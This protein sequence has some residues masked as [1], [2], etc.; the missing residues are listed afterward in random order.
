MSA[1]GASDVPSRTVVAHVHSQA[2]ILCPAFA[3]LIEAY[4][5]VLMELPFTTDVELPLEFFTLPVSSASSPSSL[6]TSPAHFTT[7][8]STKKPT[9]TLKAPLPLVP[10]SDLE[11]SAKFALVV[12]N[13]PFDASPLLRSL[14]A[15][16][17][18]LSVYA[19]G[20]AHRLFK[21]T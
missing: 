21:G 4:A 10:G 6:P 15:A 17:P 11:D 12:V 14:L 8:K 18:L 1:G 7:S 16:G 5:P 20:A 9:I 3:P 2:H 19:D 13:T